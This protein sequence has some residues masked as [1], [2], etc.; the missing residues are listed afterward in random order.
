MIMLRRTIRIKPLLIKWKEDSWWSIPFVHRVWKRVNREES[1]Q[2]L[3]RQ[4]NPTEY[5]KWE[6][7]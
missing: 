4:N 2:R 3:I 5:Y 7:A 1:K 6:M